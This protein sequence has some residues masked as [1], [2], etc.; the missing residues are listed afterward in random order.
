MHKRISL[1]ALPL[2]VAPAAGPVYG[3]ADRHLKISDGSRKEYHVAVAAHFRVKD[4]DVVKGQA[5]DNHREHPGKPAGAG[6][7][8]AGDQPGGLDRGSGERPA[9]DR[10]PRGGKPP[11][12]GGG[13]GKGR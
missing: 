2:L 10:G 13:K 9:L 4:D 12:T 8:A 1:L 3:D 5:P 11:A 7:D 6:K